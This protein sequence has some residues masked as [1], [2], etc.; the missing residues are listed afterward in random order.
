[1]NA[2]LISHGSDVDD[3]PSHDPTHPVH[4]R[5]MAMLPAPHGPSQGED[6]VHPP[7]VFTLPPLHDV[8]SYDSPEHVPQSPISQIRVR[9]FVPS[10]HVLEQGEYCDHPLHDRGVPKEEK[11]V[12]QGRGKERIM[13][14]LDSYYLLDK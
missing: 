2:L 4:T 12:I 13:V 5:V 3:D 1:V 14:R 11:R 8:L 9:V 10:P 6:G 7:H